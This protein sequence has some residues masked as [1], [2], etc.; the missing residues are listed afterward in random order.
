MRYLLETGHFIVT[1]D[2]IHAAIGGNFNNLEILFE[3]K[4]SL[5][6]DLKHYEHAVRTQNLHTLDCLLNKNR[7]DADTM[8][9]ILKYA[10]EQNFIDIVRYL[11]E[12]KKE[13]LYI[14]V[15]CCIFHV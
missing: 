1:S 8:Q 4:P 9:T 12:K 3:Y 13:P 11:V 6:I 7:V 14:H 10:I 5:S 2:V 15:V